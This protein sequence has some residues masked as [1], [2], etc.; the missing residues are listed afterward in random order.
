MTL[1][2]F[3]VYDSKALCYGVPFF[4]PSVGAAVRAFGDL[5]CDPQSSVSKHPTDYILFEVGEFN[6]STAGLVS[7]VARNLGFAS[8]F[9]PPVPSRQSR[10][11]VVDKESIDQ[12]ELFKDGVEVSS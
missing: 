7:I 11:P 12:L 6:D 3:A 5:A 8:D 2:V 4:M 9:I 1:K 10:A